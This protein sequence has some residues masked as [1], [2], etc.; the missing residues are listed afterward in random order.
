MSDQVSKAILIT[1]CS[2]GIGRATALRLASR[3]HNVYATARKLDA[4]RDLGD[5]GC[6]TLALDVC[7]EA[8]MRAAVDQ[9][10][11][12]EGAVGALVNNAGYGQDGAIEEVPIDA[13]R[14]QFETN[15][16]GL[17]RL[18]QMV[19]P[20]MRDQQWGRIVNV[21]SM[22]GKLVF[23]GGGIY[24]ATKFAIEAIS[25]ALRFEVRNFGI[26]VSVIEPGAIKTEFEATSVGSMTA[27]GSDGSPYAAFNASLE[28]R[29][30]STYAGPMSVGPEIVAKAIEHAATSK[31]P[32]SRY[33][34]TPGARTLIAARRVLP[35]AGWDA[36]M[37][38]QFT[39]PK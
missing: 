10:E 14:K 22:G 16:F 39:A 29:V 19:L 5:A 28:K 1:G 9:V 21:S 18:T 13:V 24:H 3:G 15:V 30:R 23:P 4:I 32:R 6:K 2:T 8:S 11:A 37:R 34:L 36:L 12:A 7:D 31:R 35:D 17:V 25:D 38:M 20:A 27:A 33:P 26:R